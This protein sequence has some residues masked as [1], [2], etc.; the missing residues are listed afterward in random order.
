MIPQNT[1]GKKGAGKNHPCFTPR[2]T[3]QKTPRF[4]PDMSPD[5][6]EAFLMLVF[7]YPALGVH[8]LGDPDEPGHVGPGQEIA[9]RAIFLGGIL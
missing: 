1:E 2:A 5:E 9:L 4:W 7:L 3:M 8:R 6:G